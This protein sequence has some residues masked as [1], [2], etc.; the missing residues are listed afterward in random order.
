MRKYSLMKIIPLVFLL[1]LTISLRAQEPDPPY[2][3]LPVP[4]MY[5]LLQKLK[6]KEMDV[7]NCF[8]SSCTWKEMNSFML[9]DQM[10]RV[11]KE[12]D[13]DEGKN[14]PYELYTYPNKNEITKKYN[15]EEYWITHK[16]TLNDNGT[17]LKQVMEWKD[18]VLEDSYSYKD[19]LL[20]KE[21]IIDMNGSLFTDTLV[22]NYEYKDSKLIKRY[23]NRGTK[24]EE[25]KYDKAGN[26]IQLTVETNDMGEQKKITRFS[27]TQNRLTKKSEEFFQDGKKD[28]TKSKET[29]YI[30][31][32]NG[33]LSEESYVTAKGKRVHILY[34]YT[35]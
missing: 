15:A 28:D 14:Q 7:W 9:F 19:S 20:D 27:Y 8:D 34:T 16:Y 22:Y 29:T 33:L 26:L 30:Y 32:S 12:M 3:D 23:N 24:S 4:G 11:D 13:V 5:N 31:E 6:V 10:N 18:N 17:I 21:T 25:Y 2:P 1:L 35:Y